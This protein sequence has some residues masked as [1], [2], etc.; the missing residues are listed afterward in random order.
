MGLG[1][2]IAKLVAPEAV[3]L[4]TEFVERLRTSHD[5]FKNRCKYL[6]PENRRL[7]RQVMKLKGAR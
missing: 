7:L 2:T 3:T 5:Y 1:E 6:E 4:T